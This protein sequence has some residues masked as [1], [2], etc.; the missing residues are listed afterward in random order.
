MAKEKIVPQRDVAPS[1]QSEKTFSDGEPATKQRVDS[2][3]RAPEPT[4]ASFDMNA[5]I[6]WILQ[7]GVM[8]SSFVI[9]VGIILSFFHTGPRQF[10]IFPHTLSAVWSGLLLLQPPAII[11]LGLL[12]LLATPVIR[13]A[14][15]IIAFGL[16]HDRRYVVIT[17]AV[18]LILIVSFLLG[19]GAG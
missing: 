4:R 13:V 7:G 2:Q 15:S 17:S 19:R 3:N 11:A 16:E 12:L 5:V 14:A 8:L 10:L 18:L 1:R 6:G 9:L